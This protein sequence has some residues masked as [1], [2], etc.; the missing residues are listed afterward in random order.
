[1]HFGRCGHPLSERQF[2]FPRRRHLAND[3]LPQTL[4]YIDAMELTCRWSILYHRARQA[5]IWMQWEALGFHLHK[6]SCYYSQCYKW[7][8]IISLIWSVINLS[9]S[10]MH[11]G[12]TIWDQRISRVCVPLSRDHATSDRAELNPGANDAS[13]W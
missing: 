10:H 4:F 7:C 13:H 2:C 9:E 1:M 8:V 6:R 11:S 5:D 12:L 3:V